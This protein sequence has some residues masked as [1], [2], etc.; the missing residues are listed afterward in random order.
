MLF[1]VHH[2][3]VAMGKQVWC[4][5][6]QHLTMRLFWCLFNHLRLHHTLDR[7]TMLTHYSWLPP[8]SINH[9]TRHSAVITVCN[10]SIKERLYYFNDPR[11]MMTRFNLKQVDF[12]FHLWLLKY[13]S[14]WDLTIVGL[15]SEN[16]GKRAYN[17][18]Y[19][20]SASKNRT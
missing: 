1:L 15:S 12:I 20:Y 8:P 16:C 14:K 2:S 9:W 13:V 7:I 3:F 5:A 6:A 10:T 19:K 17:L 4:E 18:V 11:L